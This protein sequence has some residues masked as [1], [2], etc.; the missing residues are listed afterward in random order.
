MGRLASESCLSLSVRGKL[1]RV[2]FTTLQ[3]YMRVFVRRESAAAQLWKPPMHTAHLLRDASQVAGS[4]PGPVA[5]RSSSL[6]PGSSLAPLSDLL[7]LLRRSS[8]FRP[9]SSGCPLLLLPCL[10]TGC[11]PLLL[12]CLPRDCSPLL[13]PC[14]STDRPLLLLPRLP[15]DCPDAPEEALGG[16]ALGLS[17]SGALAGRSSLQQHH[18]WVS[19]LRHIASWQCPRCSL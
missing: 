2:P 1:P 16:R 11:P 15:T 3:L 12:P 6:S 13:L 19:L 10:P 18:S 7:R 4:I 9:G 14:L 5:R 17:G 8:S